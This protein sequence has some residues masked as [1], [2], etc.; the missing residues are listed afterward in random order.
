MI[1]EVEVVWL[2]LEHSVE[3]DGSH[4]ILALSP[5]ACITRYTEGPLGIVCRIPSTRLVTGIFDQGSGRRALQGVH[6]YSIIGAA[7]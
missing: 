3:V 5:I 4:Y 2:A 6:A 7:P 1:E